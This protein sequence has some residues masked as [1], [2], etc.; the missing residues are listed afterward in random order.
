[1]TISVPPTFTSTRTYGVARDDT[2]VLLVRASNATT[3]TGM[4]WLPGGGID[5]GESPLQALTREIV[6]ETGLELV[7]ARLFDVTS[8]VRTR[9]N[10]QLVH[11]IR[12][13]YEISVSEGELNHETNGTT[14]LAC[15]VDIARLSEMQLADYTRRAISKLTQT[16]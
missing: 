13:I 2:R 12:V 10:G 1:M 8:D 6:E 5:F 7:S 14:D 4:W 15:W 16:K 11:T 9:D 3:A